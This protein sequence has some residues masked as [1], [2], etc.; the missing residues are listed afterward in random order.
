[1]SRKKNLKAVK[2]TGEQF[3]EMRGK[4]AAQGLCNRCET[5]AEHFET[6]S[7]PRCEC[8]SVELVKA[9]KDDVVA[10]SCPHCNG[11]VRAKPQAVVGCYMYRPV[12]PVVLQKRAGDGRPQFSEAMV[13]A[14][15]EGVRTACSK[16]DIDLA[17][18]SKG[19]DTMLFWMP[20]SVGL[21]VRGVV[22]ESGVDGESRRS[23]AV[24]RSRSTTAV[25]CAKRTCKRTRG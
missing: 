13:S 2:V 23:T 16:E 12:R 3:K 4:I 24:G 19:N 22:G 10:A 14:R 25:H 7:Q 21:R 17:S 5:R 11:R 1:M 15:S 8:G 18:W 6:G 9:D 20:Q